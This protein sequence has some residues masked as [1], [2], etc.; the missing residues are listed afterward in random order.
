[1]QFLARWW[2][3]L[4]LVAV[5]AAA[6]LAL[7]L[8]FGLWEPQERQLVDKQAPFGGKAVVTPSVEA[9]CPRVPPKDA[10]ARQ[11]NPEAMR[12]G[13]DALSDSD[14]GRRLPF[15]ILGILT[16]IFTAGIAMKTVSARAGAIAGLVV[17]SMPLLILQSRQCT[18]EIGTA[19]AGAASVYGL[20]AL[21][22]L[23]RLLFWPGT[24]IV[25]AF[26]ETIVGVAALAF[27]LVLGFW[28][29]GA[30]LGIAV[31]VG[32][33]A[34]A[35]GLG[36]PTIA[37]IVSLG[38]NALVAIETKID[39]KWGIG[40]RAWKYRRGDNSPALL[41][42]VI[43]AIAL[44]ALVYQIYSL[45]DPQPGLTPP[46]RAVMGKAIVA[47]TCWSPALGGAWRADDDLRYIVDSTFE[48]IAYGTFPWGILGV[49]A[50][51]AL[52]GNA[53]TKSI[54]AITLAWAAASWIGTEV[55]LRKVGFAMYA[56]FPAIAIAIGAWIDTV[57][58]ERSWRDP[59]RRGM[60]LLIALFAGI[61]I[62]NLAKDTQAFTEK[63]SS[64]LID[65]TPSTNT[66]ASAVAYPAMSKL[67]GL[68]TKAWIL[69]LGL[70]FA[71]AFAASVVFAGEKRGWQCRLGRIAPAAVLIA[72][73]VLA[74]FWSFGWQPAL[75]QNLSSKSLFDTIMALKKPGDQI[76]IQGDLGDAPKDYAPE[77]TPEMMSGREPVVQALSRPN[78]VFAIVPTT[79]LCN[80]HRDMQSKPY[81]LLDDRNVRSY[82]ISNRVDGV[83]D[84]NPLGKMIL[85]APPTQISAKPKAPVVW[86]NKIEL[87]GWDIPTRVHTGQSFTVRMY[88]KVRAPVGGA[89]QVLFHFT[90]PTYFNGD[91]FPIEKKCETSTWQPGDFIVDEHTVQ[92]TSGGYAAGHYDVWTGFFTGTNPN[93]KNM[94]ISEAPTDMR[95]KDPT[96][97]IKITSIMVD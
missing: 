48:Q 11:F 75:A 84:K 67:L 1:M 85:H 34:A 31:P 13:R 91:H 74:G 72:T 6:T 49:I 21:R 43:A 26:I 8:D 29:G 35:G 38:R 14:A 52:I 2:L 50:F 28:S 5:L 3:A 89:W 86:D 66:A 64:I 18:T 20:I 93:F 80:I 39:P 24:R 63:I 51:A 45:K 65:V 61:A 68:P 83:T 36:V 32:A 7:G 9:V 22:S 41:A 56:G 62:L 73:V 55:F 78:R 60:R 95:D 15:A 87:L 40:R 92:A 42:T 44:V 47:T 16:V 30:L 82:L 57:M 94:P 69:I 96:D 76:A 77:I 53:K 79:E 71:V 25:P 97:R 33:F 58:T 81:F 4:T 10:P 59:A 70:G 17:L 23:D 90:G 27:G 19:C 46:Q 54:G 88:Y 12:Y 37:D